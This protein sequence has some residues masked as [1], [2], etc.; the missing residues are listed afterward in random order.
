M[1]T[2]DE[3]KVLEEAIEKLKKESFEDSSLEFTN[4]QNIMFLESEVSA[5]K[6]GNS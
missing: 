3:I 4:S 6:G 1:N 2:Q 5:L